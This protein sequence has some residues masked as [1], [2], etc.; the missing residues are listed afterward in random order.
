MA[1][2]PLLRMSTPALAPPRTTPSPVVDDVIPFAV[3]TEPVAPSLKIP[4]AFPDPATPV[5]AEMMFPT[6]CASLLSNST[7]AT[8][9]ATIR[10][11]RPIPVLAPITASGPRT[12]MPTP[13]APTVV[14]FGRTPR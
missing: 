9:L 14:P 8:W 12:R 13:F 5:T 4:T 6:T 11:P 2:K 10:F 1:E 3:I 7:P